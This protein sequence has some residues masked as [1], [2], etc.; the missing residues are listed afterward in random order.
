MIRYAGV[1]VAA[2]CW[3]TLAWGQAPNVLGYQGRLYK[4]TG[5]PRSGVTSM[6]FSVHTASSGGTELW[7][8]EHT[9]GLSDGF[10]AVFLGERTPLPPVA[11]DGTDRFL[12]LSVDGVVLT[13]RQRIASVAYAMSCSIA[14]SVAST[15]ILNAGG[16]RVG[17]A[18]VIDA[19]G[20]IAVSALPANIASDTSGNAAGFTGALVGEVTGRQNSTVVAQVQGI[21]VS[22]TSPPSLK[23]G[24]VLRFDGSQWATAPLS[25]SDVASAPD[26]APVNDTDVATKAY[27]D[28]ASGGGGACY[29][30]YDNGSV[31]CAIGYDRAPGQYTAGSQP[32]AICCPTGGSTSV[33]ILVLTQ[34]SYTGAMSGLTGANAACLTELSSKEW[35]GKAR[36]SLSAANVRAFLCDTTTCNNLAPLKMYTFA[37]AGNIDTG[38]GAFTTD[39]F[40]RGPR[41]ANTWDGSSYLGSNI[42]YWTG[43]GAGPGGT[44]WSLGPHTSHCGGWTLTT[45]S[46]TQGISNYSNQSRWNQTTAS[47]GGV[48]PMICIV[49]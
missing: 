49:D 6:R 48:A 28:A 39:I 1:A 41:D 29:Y 33:G 30:V 15:G 27:V 24:M 44:M 9:V 23:P 7:T 12:E 43:R 11:F 32:Q 13:P 47:C 4:A 31:Q 26:Y 8:E 34:T 19:S 45:G 46:G 22:Q 25:A 36:Y 2:L 5:E 14:Q 3:G 37:R 40:G 16:L 21:A 35:L 10:Y 38:G 18:V 20:K 17:G 42:S